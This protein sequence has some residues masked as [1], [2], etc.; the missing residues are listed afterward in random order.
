M[1]QE[2]MNKQIHKNIINAE[3]DDAAIINAIIK[4]ADDE[5][6]ARNKTKTHQRYQV[7]K[8]NSI[9]NH[10]HNSS[11]TRDGTHVQLNIKPSIATLKKNTTINQ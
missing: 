7:G 2:N 3:D 1:C 4:I 5:R 11:S 6:S 8:S 10:K 9:T